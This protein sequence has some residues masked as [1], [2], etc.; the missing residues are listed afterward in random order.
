[1]AE[2]G[3]K[4]DDLAPLVGRDRSMISRFRRDE[5]KP[6]PDLMA[7]FA[8]ITDGKV[9]PNDWFDGLPQEEAA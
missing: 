7:R 2:N 1:M 8:E 6:T 5:M 4:D 9:L 3:K